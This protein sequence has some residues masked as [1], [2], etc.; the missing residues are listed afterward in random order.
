MPDASW[1]LG[2][3]EAECGPPGSSDTGG[4]QILVRSW[5]HCGLSGLGFAQTVDAQGDGGDGAGRVSR[6]ASW[7]GWLMHEQ[8]RPGR[9]RPR[10]GEER[11]FLHHPSDA[12]QREQGHKT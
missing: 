6:E 10:L 2:Y 12:K 8:G 7:R 11:H 9:G 1:A 4:R 5:P 3:T